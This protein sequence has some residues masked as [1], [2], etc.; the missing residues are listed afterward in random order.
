MLAVGTGSPRGKPHADSLLVRETPNSPGRM[1]KV[2]FVTQELLAGLP[3]SFLDR[4][5]V[6]TRTVDDEASARQ[7]CR[8]WGPDAVVLPARMIELGDALR[9]TTPNLSVVAVGVVP[10]GAAVDARIPVDA[11]VDVVLAELG[12][13]VGIMLRRSPRVEV[14]LVA[15][16]NP[17]G[18]AEP[19]L[20]NVRELSD[21]G[22]L[23]ECET[24]LEHG[25]QIGIEFHLPDQPD[26]VAPR[27]IVVSGDAT[28]QRYGV[29]FAETEPEHRE[30]I[31]VFVELQT[32]ARAEMTRPGEDAE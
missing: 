18:G 6:R 3:A 4:R 30:A 19:I 16:V 7:T 1:R 11:G 17:G 14:E 22:L 26:P 10:E 12:A 20:A 8:A 2:L 9:E 23:L 32:A 28:E 25:M 24:A 15:R 29:A 27:G 31:L 5:G 21:S 13:A